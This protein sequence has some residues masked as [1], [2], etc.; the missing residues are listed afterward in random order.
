MRQMVGLAIIFLAD[1]VLAADTAAPRPSRPAAVEISPAKP[2]ERAP[3]LSSLKKM[4]VMPEVTSGTKRVNQLRSEHSAGA[5]MATASAKAAQLKPVDKGLTEQVHIISINDKSFASTWIVPGA[6]YVIKGWGFGTTPGEVKLIGGFPNS[7]PKF[8]IDLWQDKV[9]HAYLEDDISGAYDQRNVTLAISAPGVLWTRKNVKFFA[10]RE[11]REFQLSPNFE[12]EL[13]G[14]GVMEFSAK[15]AAALQNGFLRVHGRMDWWGKQYPNYQGGCTPY[16]W[17]ANPWDMKRGGVDTFRISNF[18]P[19]WSAVGLE[20]YVGRTAFTE[21]FDYQGNPGFGHTLD[22]D[23][24]DAKVEPTKITV[25]WAVYNSITKKPCDELNPAF[26]STEYLIKGFA[27]GPRG[28][29]IF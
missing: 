4:V 27:E 14:T 26:S 12:T 13:N 11:V 17:Y 25:D 29:A 2:T 23:A 21:L 8:R 28:T 5:V 6:P 20:W 10:T 19:G 7:A 18:K 22:G 15:R 3:Q 1:T 24:Y 9:I 16:P